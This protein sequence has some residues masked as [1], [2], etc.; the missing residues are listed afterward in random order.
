MKK[1][2]VIDYGIGNVKSMMNALCGLNVS[3]LLTNDKQKILNSDGLILPGVGAFGKGME[4]LEKYN[5]IET[6]NDYVASGKPLLGVCLGMQMLLEESDEFQIS[7]GLGFIKGRVKKMQINVSSKDKL[8]HVSWNE[9]IIPH[10]KKWDNT[11]LKNIAPNSD[12]YFVH[13]YIV[14]PDNIDNILAQCEYGG[15]KFCAAVNY[16]NIYG[17]QFHPEKSAKIG[18]II[19]NN[20]ISII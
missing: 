11:I 3:T 2:S 19:L 10:E 13:S 4:N 17:T 18:Q 9:L 20:F 14:E 12:V 8:P 5:L 7:K 15:F 16:K 6:I 1:I